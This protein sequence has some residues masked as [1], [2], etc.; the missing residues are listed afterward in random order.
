M[1]VVSYSV[2]NSAR[3]FRFIEFKEHILRSFGIESTTKFIWVRPH[4]GVFEFSP[5]EKDGFFKRT[6]NLDSRKMF[7]VSVAEFSDT[8]EGNVPLE[9]GRYSM[10]AT[11][12]SD[13]FRIYLVNPS[14]R[15]C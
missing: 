12:L 5:D 3:K 6:V 8:F 10:R 13:V 4:K 11:R 7:K 1:S 9:S 15:N 14:E 2:L